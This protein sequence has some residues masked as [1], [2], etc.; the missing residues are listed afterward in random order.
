[1]LG[2][3]Q[4][5]H[6]A[7]RHGAF[8]VSRQHKLCLWWLDYEKSLFFVGPSSKTP[9]TRKW[10][11]AWL[12]ARDG[13]FLL[14]LPPP[15]LASRAIP[16]LN[17]KKKG[18]CLHSSD[19]QRCLQSVNHKQFPIQMTQDNKHNKWLEILDF[20][21]K[22]LWRRPTKIL[23]ERRRRR[24][25][26]AAESIENIAQY[27]E[28]NVVN[29]AT[30][31]M[32]RGSHKIRQLHC[33]WSR[34][35]LGENTD[36]RRFKK[37]WGDQA[38]LTVYSKIIFFDA[39]IGSNGYT[40]CTMHV[41]NSF[42]TDWGQPISL[43]TINRGRISLVGRTLDCRRGGRGF[44]SRGRTNTQGLKINLEMKVPYLFE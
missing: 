3:R 43:Y 27:S 44:S 41:K 33:K 4:W 2:V 17:L 26:E 39:T 1:M 6:V 40:I 37:W 38:T 19:D 22:L 36:C 35:S 30:T 13:K 28:G 20:Q 10:P 34:G 8:C 11:R 16:L 32:Y 29:T 9:V 12:K 31:N 15:F 23:R 14:V 18:D 25:Q 42:P 7:L 21:P 24:Q 5:R